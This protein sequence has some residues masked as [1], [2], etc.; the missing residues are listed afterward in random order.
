MANGPRYRVKFRRR[1]LGRTNYY[2]RVGLISSGLPR[3]AI[4]RS[5]RYVLA[6]LITS[7][8]A[9]DRVLVS[10][11]SRE[12]RS[13][14][15][16][17]G[18]SSA[19][20]CYLTGHLIGL[21]VLQKGVKEAIVDLGQIT[22]LARTDVYAVVKGCVD[23]GVSVRHGENVFPPEERLSG[24]HIAAYAQSLKEAAPEKYARLFSQYLKAGVSPEK[25]PSLVTSVRKELIKLL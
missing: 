22:K 24:E 6:Q 12:L 23:A 17:A 16:P 15:Y 5:N 3:L 11:S 9:K 2:R 10:A 21:R 7:D 19:P 8:Q 20:A 1:R 13:V 18:L 14:G 4:R 25:L